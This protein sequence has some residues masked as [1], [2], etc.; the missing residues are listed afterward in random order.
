MSQIK[1]TIGKRI[2]RLRRNLNMTQQELAQAIGVNASYIGPLEKGIK[3]PSVAVLEKLSEILGQPVFSFFLEETGEE[4]TD[5][6]A[7]RMS[8]ILAP[9]THDERRFLVHMAEEM[10]VL[11][12]KRR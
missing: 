9:H 7:L 1:L 5:C 2:H 3:C 6:S 11:L 4:S 8:A 10:S 12:R